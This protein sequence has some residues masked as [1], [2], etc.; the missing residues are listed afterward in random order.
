MKLKELCRLSGIDCPK[1]AEETEIAFVTD[2]TAKVKEG[3]LFVAIRGFTS[4][5]I[6][7][8]ICAYII[9]LCAQ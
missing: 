6:N 3:S 8:P 4:D 2:H 1:G 9:T 7:L 5:G